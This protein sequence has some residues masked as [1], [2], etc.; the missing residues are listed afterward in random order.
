M[1][2]VHTILALSM[3]CIA[4]CNCTGNSLACSFVKASTSSTTG[5]AAGI[6]SGTDSESGLQL[7][8]LI[9]ANGQADFI[10]SDGVQF[11]GTA[12]V[13]GT[14]L[15]IALDGYTQ[16]DYQFS[17]G[18]TFGTGT[19]S[20]TFDSGSTIS[21]S[22]QFTTEDTTTISSS[23][24]LTFASLYNTAS[25]LGTV[26]GTYTDHLAAV[27]DGLDPLSGSSVTISS[28]GVLYA[29]G[30]T[31]GCVANGTV[32]VT[33]ASYDLYQVSYTLG[34]CSGS[35]AALDGVPFTGMA[36]LNTNE[37]PDQIIIAVT[38]EGTTGAYYGI[39]SDL[40]TS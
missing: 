15:D 16:Y 2:C 13:T 20:G 33:N 34:D 28:S 17:D 26:S 4:G 25:S 3:I 19:F 35:Y 38:G 8:G 18:S 40:S 29:Q 14:T 11:V 9:N 24:S 36:E 23:W 32:T 31:D 7:T 27:S 5:T 12:Q 30:S 10:R 22:L 37:S 1:K 39:V 21:G 6:W